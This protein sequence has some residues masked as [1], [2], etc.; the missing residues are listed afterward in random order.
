MLPSNGID[1]FA[2]ISARLLQLV[3]TAVPLPLLPSHR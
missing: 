2:S 1:P 3:V